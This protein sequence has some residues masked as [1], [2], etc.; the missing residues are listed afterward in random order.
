MEFTRRW[1]ASC[2]EARMLKEEQVSTP[3]ISQL[4]TQARHAY[5]QRRT[6]ECVGL[7]KSLLDLDSENSEGR[8]LQTAIQKELQ[9][10]LTDA[11]ALIEDS[12]NRED[13]AKYRKAAEIILLKVMYLDPE[14]AA[15]KALL[16]NARAI[17]EQQAPLA[18]PPVQAPE[19]VHTEV[20]FTTGAADVGAPNK[21]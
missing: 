12:K 3:E 20:P 19:N 4:E 18:S 5:E 8:R 21:E 9:R 1:H 2:T 13:G 7:I 16:A 17:D 11:H 10:D 14:N 6:R 15:A